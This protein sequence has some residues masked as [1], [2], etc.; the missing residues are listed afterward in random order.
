MGGW[1]STQDTGSVVEVNINEQWYKGTVV[2][3]GL[4]KK[5]LTV[6][7][8]DDSLTL[9]K[10]THRQVRTYQEPVTLEVN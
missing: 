5:H 1:S 9:H 8:D 6:I 7:L 10:V 2:D 4:G 3:S